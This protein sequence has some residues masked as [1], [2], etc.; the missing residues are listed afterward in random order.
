[1]VVVVTVS[2]MDS[3]L[4]VEVAAFDSLNDLLH[5]GAQYVMTQRAR[6][7]SEA[8]CKI[9]GGLSGGHYQWRS[10]GIQVDAS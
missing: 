9:K 3:R 4:A 7:G 5:G 2:N 1:M 6:D 10:A 8:T